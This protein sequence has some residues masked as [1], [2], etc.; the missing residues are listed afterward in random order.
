VGFGL[1]RRMAIPSEVYPVCDSEAFTSGSFEA[2]YVPLCSILATRVPPVGNDGTVALL[3][4]V[5]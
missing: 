2:R 4:A 1:Y 3:I 5:G